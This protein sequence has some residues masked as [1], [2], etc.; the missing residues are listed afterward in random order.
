MG[1]LGGDAP[2]PDPLI[3]Q[4]A[5]SN[6]QLSK[7]SL[8]WYKQTY[9]DSILPQEQAQT[10]MAQKISDATVDSMH[11]Q[12][13]FAQDQNNY[14]KTTFQTIETKVASDAM[15]YDSNDNVN[16]RMGI[17]TAGVRQAYSTAEASSARNLARYGVNPNSSAF[18]NA[19]AA[20][21]N[22]EALATAGAGTGA[23]FD[24]L[25]KGIALRAGAANFGRNM[26]NTAATYYAGA[27]GAGGSAAN[28]SAQ[29][30]GVNQAGIAGM[31]GAFGSA[32]NLNASGAGISNMDFS[33][34]MAGYSANQ[35]AIGGMFQ[36]LGSLA[37][38]ATGIGLANYLKPPVV[39]ADGGEIDQPNG[40]GL[41]HGPGTGIS[42]NVAAVNT[43][44]GQPIRLSNNE[45]I[46]PA[47]V[48]KKK[49]LEFFDKLIE[50]HHV[51]AQA[52]R[53]G[54]KRG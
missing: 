42:D 49:G 16:K 21:V 5:A 6:V 48:V 31:S 30:V 19:N 51:P 29:S 8:D 9:A 32:G 52:Q 10:A 3:G 15:N 27:T 11:Q 39:K 36:G 40:V 33:G 47:D 13:Q 53:M 20:L 12:D 25:D 41:V 2:A 14:Y 45:Y 18:A 28:T 34:R 44:T 22:N 26:P 50:K 24:T 37:G 38:T 1:W 43:D 17:A 46:I 7:D 35:Q 23:A 54:I 4:A